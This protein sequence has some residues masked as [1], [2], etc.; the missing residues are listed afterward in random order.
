[1]LLFALSGFAG[2]VY[3]SMWTQYLGLFLGHAAHAQSFVLILFMGG[4]ALGAWL[5]S[6]RSER[7]TRPLAAYALVELVVG[8]LGIGF[9]PLYHGLTGLAYDH[10]FPA[11]GLGFGVEVVRYAIAALLIGLQCVL[12]GT[13]FPLMSAGY[14]RLTPGSGGRVLASLYFSNSFGAALGALA[15]TFLLV[16]AVGLPGAVMAGGLL[17]VLVAIAI[18]PLARDNS[19]P[20]MAESTV[21]PRAEAIAPAFVLSAAALTG[22]TSFVYEITWIRMLSQALGSTLHAFEL[23]LAA[24]ILGIAFGG[25]WLRRKA[26]AWPNALFAAGWAQVLMGIAAL[27]SLFVYT[28]AFDWVEALLAGLARSEQ[29]Y[30]Y[31]NLA[32]GLVSLAVMFPAAFFAG[33]TL[34]LLTLALIRR[35]GGERAIGRVYAANT[36][37]AI[38]GVLLTVHVLM[39]LFGVRIGLWLA[40]IAD[41][42]LGVF[43]ILRGD[44]A[45]VLSAVRRH[46]FAAVVLSTAAGV[47]SLMLTRVEPLVLASSVYRVGSAQLPSDTKMMFYGDGKTATVAMYEFQTDGKNRSIA[48][49]GKVD[50]S[51]V[52]AEGAAPS[53]DEYTMTLAAALPLAMHPAPDNVAVIGFGSGMTAHTFMGDDRVKRQDVIEI[54]PF[55][56]DAARN[57]GVRVDRA[58]SDPRSHVVIDDAKAFLSGAERR[59]DIIISEPSNPWVS[60]VAGLFTGEFY[61]FVPK[62]LEE[63]GIFVQWLQLYEIDPALVASVL[64]AMLPR[65]AD[66]RAY[67]SNQTD[68]LMVASVDRPL[69]PLGE[70]Q[71]VAP[72]LGKELARLGIES[73]EDFELHY[74]MDRRG[75]AALAEMS[76][77]AANSD[78]FP[79]LQLRAPRARFVSADSLPIVNLQ[80]A[81]WPLLEVA[82]GHHPF[83]ASKALSTVKKT[84]PRDAMRRAAIALHRG[85]RDGAPIPLSFSESTDLSLRMT[86]VRSHATACDIDQAADAWLDAASQIASLTIPFF[87]AEDLRGVWIDPVWIG[88]CTP[89]DPRIAPAMALFSA[90]AARDWTS[91]SSKGQELLAMEQ[92][93][94]SPRFRGYVLGAVEL[95]ML[96]MG[97]REGLI[98]TEEAHGGHVPDNVFERQWMMILAHQGKDRISSSTSN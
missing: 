76:T 36:I 23:M 26:D 20:A 49:N 11:V 22:A 5:V 44:R 78:Y 8:I 60:G 35:G 21:A 24:F 68:M 70:I 37:G 41:L 40:A 2:L 81:P 82:A 19:A 14:L 25:L 93:A 18:W 51:I 75:L 79:V 66:V 63:G 56:V 77:I 72:R 71:A 6:R 65:F 88:E 90:V 42:A 10:L 83:T 1:M 61:D 59:Y 55:M 97:D 7:F 69:P 91:A 45:M 39:P 43:L 50:A 3:E 57:F 33:M 4:M 31:Y 84:V 95:A 9:D 67:V 48:T 12:L 34:P 15:A 94:A 46:A 54:E 62:H 87:P 58:Y 27:G 28:R 96:A 38:V 92:L 13:T 86:F 17:S 29:G 89:T 64:K 30:A 32:T 47:A 85:M 98:A 73:T 52:M 74:L 16:P 53:P 80:R